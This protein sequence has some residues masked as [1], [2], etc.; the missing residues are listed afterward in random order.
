[1]KSIV[2]KR[3]L[4]VTA[5]LFSAHFSHAQNQPPIVTLS[6]DNTNEFLDVGSAVILTAQ[7]SDQDGFIQAIE[8]FKNGQLLAN[9][10]STSNREVI[11]EP[12]ISY[13]HAVAYDN[14]SASATSAVVR[15]S[16][17]IPP[18]ITMT[19]PKTSVS[20]YSLSEPIL[21]TA[22]ASDADGSIQEVRLLQNGI[23]V[24]ADLQAP[25]E[26]LYKPNS[27][28][29]FNLQLLAI[30][31]RGSAQATQIR[32]VHYVR[33]FDNLEFAI[34]INQTTNLT[35]RASNV[36]ATH[37]KGEPE[38][39][40]VTGGKSVW[41][42]WRAGANGTVTMDTIG[43][44]FDTVIGVYTN[45]LLQGINF[46]NM[47][48]VAS[49]DNDDPIEPLSRVKFF[50]RFGAIYYIAVDGRD[51]MA[52]NIKLNIRQT[53][54]RAPAHDFIAN[55][56]N[57]VPL[58][59]S[60]NL[61][62]TSEPGEPDH[63]ENGGGASM[64]YRL[65]VNFV[66]QQWRITTDGSNFD[67][68]LAIYTNIVVGAQAQQIPP[69]MENLRLAAF[70]DDGSVTN[71]SQIIL[72]PKT[73]GTYWIAVDGYNGAQ[74][75]IR[76]SATSFL[77]GSAPT[78]DFFAKATTLVGASALT[79]VNTTR[80]TRES[81]EPA[82]LL[83]PIGFSTRSVWYRWIAPQSG[84]VYMTTEWSDFDTVLAV[85]TGTNLSSVSLVASN[86]DDP[87]GGQTSALIFNAIAGTEYRI[88]IAGY[89]G[90]AGNLVFALNQNAFYL[91]RLITQF[92]PGRLLLSIPDAPKPLLLEGSTDLVH[93]GAVRILSATDQLEVTI[94]EEIPRLFYRVRMSE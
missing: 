66:G 20:V 82:P 91:P 48:E 18:S 86:D 68:V 54:S 87:T 11:V 32:T 8:L 46:T 49:N 53:I 43:S 14:M 64:W 62:A 30:D 45:R 51:G 59:T 25:W 81:F 76:F 6:V 27:Y 34:P 83:D 73:V 93:W 63:G 42:A 70:N 71:T 90:A 55:A 4:A 94:S 35:L 3:L 36:G 61:G 5:L 67:T 77:E 80:A 10:G 16:G 60:N 56:V 39:A 41:F 12:G 33:V 29:S 74:G 78:N 65:N 19:E 7:A 57:A 79:N 47:V 92:L 44:D 88:G 69:A 50:A 40:G 1:M 85:Y 89:R 72:T 28:G 26:F 2:P 58:H 84:P 17:N 38:H 15:I 23:P 31:N 9:I 13:Y 21:I 37:Q 75:T 24:A 22:G 52:G